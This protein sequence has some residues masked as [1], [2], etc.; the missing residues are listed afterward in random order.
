MKSFFL[1]A[2][3]AIILLPSCE[4]QKNCATSMELTTSNRTP[5]VGD[6]VTIRAII[7]GDNEHFFWDGP[8][9]SSTLGDAVFTIHNIK[10]S[11]SG[12]YSCGKANSDCNTSLGD[13]ILIEVQLK[14][15]TPPCSMTNNTLTSNNT[16]NTTYTSVTQ[17]ID[18]LS[19]GVTLN[20]WA[21]FYPEVHVLFNHYNGTGEPGDGLYVTRGD[22][23]FDLFGEPNEISLQFVYSGNIYHVRADQK[24]YVSHVGG[25]LQVSF[26]NI[27][28]AASN[29]ITTTCS[30]KMTE[31]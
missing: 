2:F 18:A 16:P 21:A 15:E 6:D 26:C 13:T 22:P 3:S 20:A 27:I 17:G 9:M 28:F 23:N 30:G 19:N 1:F 24:V 7:E 4:K 11:E 10:L 29:V 8:A 14:Q 31:L 5:T 25:K 12:V